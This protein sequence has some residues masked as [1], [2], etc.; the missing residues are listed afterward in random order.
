[1]TYEETI[2]KLFEGFATNS[3]DKARP[4]LTM[5][6]GCRTR[7]YTPRLGWHA[8]QPSQPDP[9]HEQLVTRTLIAAL[10]QHIERISNDSDGDAL[11]SGL[12]INN[13]WR[14]CLEHLTD[15]YNFVFVVA[16]FYENWNA[17][18]AQNNSDVL[19]LAI[20]YPL[21]QVVDEWLGLKGS[22]GGE[23]TTRRFLSLVFGD[24]W[25]DLAL[26]HDLP[27]WKIKPI[28]F[29]SKPPFVAGLVPSYVNVTSID[30]P[31][32]EHMRT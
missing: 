19:Q 1:M 8:A 3:Y 29:G 25:C 18:L 16:C 12:L 30:L 14:L 28:M 10:E 17:R 11:L 5:A 22:K 27:L 21:R 9:A 23:M 7:W 31:T 15:A 20:R 32:L 6:L 2:G 24:L 26:E 13:R 4:H